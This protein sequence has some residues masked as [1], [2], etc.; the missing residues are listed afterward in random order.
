MDRCVDMGYMIDYLVNE[1]NLDEDLIILIPYILIAFGGLEFDK[2]KVEIIDDTKKRKRNRKPKLK[3]L[4]KISFN[5][6]YEAVE[7]IE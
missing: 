6:L 1:I 4:K 2:E 3:I 7:K 5:E